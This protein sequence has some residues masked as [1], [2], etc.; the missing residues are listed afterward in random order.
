MSTPHQAT[1]TL[2]FSY[3]PSLTF[4]SCA[5]ALMIGL[6]ALLIPSTTKRHSLLSVSHW[7]CLAGL[8]WHLACYVA[9]AVA[10]VAVLPRL[11]ISLGL[12]TF[13][14][15]SPAVLNLLAQLTV[16][17]MLAA[18]SRAD[19][20]GRDPNHGHSGYDA[21]VP[22]AVEPMMPLPT[23]HDSIANYWHHGRRHSQV[24]SRSAADAQNG[25]SGSAGADSSAELSP[26]SPGG[27]A[28]SP[29]RT[30]VGQPAPANQPPA[31]LVSHLPLWGYT[32]RRNCAL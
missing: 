16:A 2:Y 1:L 19:I 29:I 12:L 7:L 13:S 22:T 27:G 24:M 5:A 11:A 30:R 3:D 9:T 28:L 17:M 32:S 4:F 23:L 31:S 10:A 25:V 14:E 15:G 8:L 20:H 26:G 6:G 21:T 18:L